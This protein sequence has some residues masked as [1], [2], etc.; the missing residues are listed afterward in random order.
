M[1]HTKGHQGNRRAN[2]KLRSTQLK[3]CSNCKD[4]MLQHRICG[5]CGHYAGKQRIDVMA[6]LNKKE[7][8]KKEK[9]LQPTE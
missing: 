3:Q 1:R 9:E 7:R 6:K 2:I 4:K 5:N 8:K